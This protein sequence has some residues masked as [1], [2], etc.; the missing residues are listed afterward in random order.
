MTIWYIE[1]LIYIKED[2]NMNCS[3]VSLYVAY[4][5]QTPSLLPPEYSVYLK[6]KSKTLSEAW[7]LSE[8]PANHTSHFRWI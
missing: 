8:S 2:S 5:S 3:T 1:G 7:E 6:G 4:R